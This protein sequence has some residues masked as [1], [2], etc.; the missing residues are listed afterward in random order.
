MRQKEGYALAE[1]GDSINLAFPDSANRH[2]MVGKGISNTVL[3]GNQQGVVTEKLQIR[4]LTP[5]EYWRLQAF[6]DVAFYAAKFS[7][8]KI[9][10]E[11]TSHG[12]NHYE[13]QYEQKISDSQLYKQAGNSVT[14]EVIY[15][16]AK[17]LL[18]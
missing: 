4:K 17:Q 14:V 8:R 9:A 3:T 1:V 18:L 5:L 10:E 15:Q 6:P 16:I 13:C 11:I 7:S 2:G 12:L